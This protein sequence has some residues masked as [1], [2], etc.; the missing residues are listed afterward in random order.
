MLKMVTVF[1]RRQDVSSEAFYDHWHNE[2][3]A[4]VRE[5]AET[6]RVRRYVQSARVPSQVWDDF[7]AGRG[8]LDDY[9]ALA[10]T[11]WDSE[12]DMLEAFASPG[13]QAASLRLAEDEAVFIDMQRVVSFLSEE[14]DVIGGSGFAA[15]AAAPG[16]LGPSGRRVTR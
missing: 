5:V 16:D 3:A 2:H 9:D 12:Q 14:H 1:A 8:W 15:S 7:V 10:E 6:L 13:G 4:I 11:W